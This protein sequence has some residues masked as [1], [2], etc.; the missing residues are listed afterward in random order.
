MPSRAT[1]LRNPG[2][3]NAAGFS[4]SSIAMGNDCDVTG[5]VAPQNKFE[6]KLPL[7]AD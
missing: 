6:L 2:R 7:P 5:Y 4:Q 1:F 3:G